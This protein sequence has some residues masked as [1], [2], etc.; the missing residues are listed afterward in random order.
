MIENNPS[1]WRV[2]F[3][4]SDRGSRNMA[5]DEALLESV[6]G[7]AS[8]PTLRFY[9]WAPAC[10]SLGYSQPITDVDRLALGTQEWDLVRRATGGRAILHTDELTYA[11]IAP[12][13]HPALRG[14]VLE[15]YLLL[16]KGLIA[17]MERLGL[18]VD[19]PQA[20][21][22]AQGT[23]ENPVCFEVPSAYEIT[24]GGKKLLGS[25]QLRRKD[26]ILQHG[27]LPLTG[28][29][30]RICLALR[31]DDPQARRVARERL[32]ERASTVESLLDRGVSMQ[33]AAQAVQSGFEDA[34]NW[35]FTTGAVTEDEIE[36]AQELEQSRYSNSAW[37]ERV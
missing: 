24:C 37:T 8:L 29:I 13:N 23:T 26:G 20:N 7:G 25:A 27:S 34:L 30:S 5:L 14:G 18:S 32:L 31:Y 6:G 36:R 16:S 4:G 2:I 17:G 33:D 9:G 1:Q 3:S 12:T 22:I 35:T 19:P 11:I 21:P 15:S 10:L 28:D